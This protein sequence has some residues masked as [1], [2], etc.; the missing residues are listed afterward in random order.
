MTTSP[1]E[2][3]DEAVTAAQDALPYQAAEYVD[4]DYM[5]AALEAAAPFMRAE[6]ERDRDLEDKADEARRE[7][8]DEKED[9]L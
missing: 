7:W 9:E 3:P 2:I 1:F 8:L 6:W 4:E 5:R